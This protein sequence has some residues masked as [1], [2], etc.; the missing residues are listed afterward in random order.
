MSRENLSDE[1]LQELFAKDGSD[2]STESLAEITD[3]QGG[4]HFIS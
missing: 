1:E 3:K 4:S 2:S